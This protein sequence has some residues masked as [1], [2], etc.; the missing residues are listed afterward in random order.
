MRK[1]FMH[2][3]WALWAL[4]AI[5]L[6]T[7]CGV[8]KA[9]VQTPAQSAAKD[10]IWKSL[11]TPFGTGT[12]WVRTLTEFG[13]VKVAGWVYWCPQDNGTWSPVIH[14]CVV[15]RGCMDPAA[16]SS[17]L[18]T[19]ARS[20]DPLAALVEARKAFTMPVLPSE[21]AAWDLAE[22]ELV[23]AA[24]KIRPP[25]Q[26]YIVATATASDGTRPAYPF[27]NGVRS[28]IASGRATSG[29]PCQPSKGYLQA[30]GTDLWAVFGPVFDASRVALCVRKP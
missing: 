21:Q 20:A 10:C 9:Q 17:M 29:Q 6:T 7:V 2:S 16:L 18:D 14:R 12:E 3:L 24:A 23:Q 26:A 1:S 27:A 13:G 19:A 5:P 30:S 15:G 28:T 25:D 8:A 4:L 11:W 22:G